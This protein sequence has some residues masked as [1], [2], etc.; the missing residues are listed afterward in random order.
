MKSITLLLFLLVSGQL[1]NDSKA[2]N[3]LI[4]SLKSTAVAS[5]ELIESV[6]SSADVILLTSV[7][8]SS[9]PVTSAD[10]QQTTVPSVVPSSTWAT[11]KKVPVTECEKSFVLSD[12]CLQNALFIGQQRADI[13]HSISHM[14]EYCE[15][16]K[17]K[18]NCIR[19]YGSK[20][21]KNVP[22][23]IYLTITKNV[24]KMFKEFCD[25]DSGK[26]SEFISLFVI[27]VSG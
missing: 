24:R 14:D 16:K 13:P 5:D 18:F 2:K 7:T 11:V 4:I 21:L 26:N 1:D 25:T 9:P 20:C 10:L 6:V 8:D 19:Q 23:Q 15:D 27:V 17:K 12:E 3:E 22:R